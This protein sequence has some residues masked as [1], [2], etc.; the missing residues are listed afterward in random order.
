MLFMS[1]E[2]VSTSLVT[3]QMPAYNASHASLTENDAVV[4]SAVA[5]APT[6]SASHVDLVRAAAKQIDSYLKSTNR[7]L[8]IHV[9]HDTGKTVVVVRDSESGEVIRQIPDEE[10][11]RLAKSLGSGDTAAILSLSA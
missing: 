7:N 1:I 9:D 5:P 4:A 10:A 3:G 2:Q 6:P 11:L 8:D